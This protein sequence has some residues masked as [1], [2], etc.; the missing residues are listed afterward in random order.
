M[1][2]KDMLQLAF[3][4]FIIFFLKRKQPLFGT[5]ILTD[6]CNLFCRHCKLHNY[7]EKEYTFEQLC[8]DMSNM[9]KRGVRIL[10]LS[11]G[12]IALWE[13]EEHTVKE[14]VGIAKKMGFLYVTLATNGT[15]P[16][17]YGDADFVLVSIDGSRES[18]NRIRGDSYDRALSNIRAAKPDKIV[19]YMTINK[20]NKH[21]I[22]EVCRLAKNEAN[23]RAVSFNFLTPFPGTEELALS[24]DEKESCSRQICSYM[25]AGYPILNLKSCL[26]YLV[27]GT[28]PKPCEQMMVLDHG[29]ELLCNRCIKEPGL[30][31]ECGYFETAEISMMFQGKITVITDA[32]KTYRKYL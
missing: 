31:R 12:E 3:H 18:H 32:L 11:G 14:L 10:C 5:L 23:I 19:I 15:I 27:E 6:Q 4:S 28:F 25:E 21:E 22:G 2:K 24:Q 20:W 9:Y 26:P 30:C 17:D 16:I 7:N 29:E 13:N 8:K 1:K